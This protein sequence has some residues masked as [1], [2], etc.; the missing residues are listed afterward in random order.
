M[1]LPSLHAGRAQTAV[2]FV[3]HDAGDFP[4]VALSAIHKHFAEQ[5]G[6]WVP[7]H[8]LRF[9]LESV[10]DAPEHLSVQNR[11]TGTM[12]CRLHTPGAWQGSLASPRP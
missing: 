2:R 5:N 3:E 12:A 1:F 9:A 4:D 11:Q 7:E 8:P 10:E 6:A